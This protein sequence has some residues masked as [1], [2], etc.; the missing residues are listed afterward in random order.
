MTKECRSLSLIQPKVKRK[1]DFVLDG[2]TVRA[3]MSGIRKDP[4][5]VPLERAIQH[6]DVTR[7]FLSTI[8][9][10]SAQETFPRIAKEKL[11]VH[12]L[13][14]FM[15]PNLDL[16]PY[17]PELPGASGLFFAPS[18]QATRKWEQHVQRVIT[19]LKAGAWLYVGQYRIVPVAS[20]TKDEWASQK[21]KVLS[22]CRPDDK[23]YRRN[24]FFSRFVMPGFEK[25][26]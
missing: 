13:N 24:F 12:G 21:D 23:P 10:G 11:A 19:R 5:P 8:Y 26:A 4:Y 20:L 16:N 18:D 1:E 22:T 17:A 25:Y 15:Y 2:D 6:V 3:R 7:L 14:D 9:G